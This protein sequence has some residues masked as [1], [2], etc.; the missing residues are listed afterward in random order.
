M[1]VIPVILSGLKWGLVNFM[2]KI[3]TPLWPA[4]FET[5]QALESTAGNGYDTSV[6]LNQAQ[7]KANSDLSA[8]I[9]LV[10]DV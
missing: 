3:F 9:S 6:P 2:I 1:S 4:Y 8:A 10:K 5:V 7:R